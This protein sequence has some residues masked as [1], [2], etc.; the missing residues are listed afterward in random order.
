M[1][2]FEFLDG[3][4]VNLLTMESLCTDGS[5]YWLTCT[6]GTRYDLTAEEFATIKDIFKEKLQSETNN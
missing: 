6:S 3:S 4:I 2:I 1:L 5:K